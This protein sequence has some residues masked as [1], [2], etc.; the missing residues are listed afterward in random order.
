MNPLSI[1]FDDR[2][3]CLI[4]NKEQSKKSWAT[5][6]STTYCIVSRNN[7]SWATN[8]ST[9]YCIVS[10]NNKSRKF[11]QEFRKVNPES[12]TSSLFLMAL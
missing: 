4:V 11:D 12:N 3:S 9:T 2:F 5:N 7:K 8:N 10:R 6:N 1:L